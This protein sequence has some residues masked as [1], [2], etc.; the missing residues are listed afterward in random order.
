MHACIGS[1][2]FRFARAGT[3]SQ[4][5]A[6]EASETASGDLSMDMRGA[7]SEEDREA[8]AL[9][10]KKIRDALVVSHTPGA[11]LSH[12]LARGRRWAWTWR[13][14]RTWRG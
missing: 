13:R 11:H 9:K 14:P 5:Y 4:R 10:T 2:C 1:L 7:R 3:V 6:R 12:D 8:H